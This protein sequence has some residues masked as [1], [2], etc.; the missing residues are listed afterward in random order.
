MVA[1]ELTEEQV[2]DRLK[3]YV[4]LAGSQRA[5]CD[6]H[7]LAYAF[8]SRVVNRIDPPSP[9]LLKAIDVERVTL[10]RLVL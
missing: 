10:Y 8:I 3:K 2:I 4:E 7:D 9:D 1:K 5:F 6:K